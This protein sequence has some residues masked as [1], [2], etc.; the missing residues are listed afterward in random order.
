MS[1]QLVDTLRAAREL[2]T[3][4]QNWT[5]GYYAANGRGMHVEPEEDSATCFC[6]LGAIRR[7]TQEPH[8]RVYFKQ[9]WSLLQEVAK[10]ARGTHVADVND[11]IGHLAV[12]SLYDEA[13]KRAERL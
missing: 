6:A 4:P 9:A 8:E 12:L 13:I 5:Q 3:E 10:D 2:I 11:N 7:V 1:K